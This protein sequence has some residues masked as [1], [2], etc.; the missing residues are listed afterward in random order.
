MTDESMMRPVFGCKDRTGVVRRVAVYTTSRSLPGLRTG[1]VLRWK[2]PHFNYFG[3]GSS[4]ARIEDED[5]AN[6]SLE[7]GVSTASTCSSG[8]GGSMAEMLGGLDTLP[9]DILN[10][11]LYQELMGLGL[12]GKK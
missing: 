6:I 11:P 4:G 12:G 2:N 3:D 10:S 8:R 9:P 7:G 1:A 5:V